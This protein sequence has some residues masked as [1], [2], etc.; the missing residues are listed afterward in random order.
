MKFWQFLIVVLA[1]IAGGIYGSVAS[2]NFTFD[3][4]VPWLEMAKDWQKVGGLLIWF[5]G[6]WEIGAA[7]FA[8]LFAVGGAVVAGLLGLVFNRS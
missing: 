2:W 1:A 4:I 6:V 8:A 7:L 3:T 5:F